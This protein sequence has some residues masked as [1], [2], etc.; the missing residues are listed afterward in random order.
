M[1]SRKALLGE[2]PPQIAAAGYCRER[3]T[4]LHTTPTEYLRTVRL[5]SA[6]KLLMETNTT[7]AEI[8]QTRGALRPC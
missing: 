5:Q 2:L 6:C 8:A 4:C 7:V 1:K 3:Q